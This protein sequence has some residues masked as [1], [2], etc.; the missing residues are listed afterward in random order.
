MS[1]VEKVDAEVRFEVGLKPKGRIPAY[2]TYRPLPKD[3]TTVKALE[4]YL[5]SIRMRGGGDD[6]K[7]LF[8]HKRFWDGITHKE[9]LVALK[10]KVQATMDGF[11]ALPPAQAVKKKFAPSTKAQVAIGSGAGLTLISVVEV[12]TR[13]F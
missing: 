12:L 1:V 7:I 3:H 13:V 8:E 9:H 11:A 4:D 6:T 10:V 5:F 2:E